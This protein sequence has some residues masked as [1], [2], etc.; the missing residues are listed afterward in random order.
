MNFDLPTSRSYTHRVGRTTRVGRTGMS[1]SF[2]V[3]KELW[4][5]N[6][7]VGCL[8]SPAKDDAVFA[9]FEKEREQEG[10]RSRST[11]LI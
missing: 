9:K 11:I 10:V 2:I 5:K 8:P 4:G 7:V 3:P 6:K 1:L